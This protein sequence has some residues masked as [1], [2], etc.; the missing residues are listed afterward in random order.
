VYILSSWIIDC[1]PCAGRP[2]DR[3]NRLAADPKLAAHE[4]ADYRAPWRGGIAIVLQDRPDRNA[5]LARLNWPP[6]HR[7]ERGHAL[8][9]VADLTNASLHHAIMSDIV[10]RGSA[11]K[12]AELAERFGCSDDAVRAA[13]R[14]LA[15]FLVRRD[16]REWWG[17]CAWCSLGIAALVGG[18]VTITT[19][20][21]AND[22]QVTIRVDD[23]EVDTRDLLVHF[24]I[25]MTR[26][27][28]NVIYACSMMLVFDSEAKIDSWCAYGRHLDPDW[29]KWTVPEARALIDRHGLSGP[30]WA[31]PSTEG[32]F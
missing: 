5:R 17:N 9:A 18:P 31:L 7:D 3:D 20:L 15:D 1:L 16:E 14:R 10:G 6:P 28:N 19:T 26:V 23:G 25:P 21:G 24:P 27:W 2:L 4:H 8:K 12:A 29:H 11:P 13:L 22:S 32:R 30:I